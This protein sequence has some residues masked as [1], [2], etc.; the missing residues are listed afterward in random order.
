MVTEEEVKAGMCGFQVLIDPMKVKEISAE[1]DK[2]RKRAKLNIS[3]TADNIMQEG[4]TMI[5]P[6]SGQKI[7]K[8][9][10]TLG[11]DKNQNK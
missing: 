10:A 6:L 7:E 2:Q 9:D 11:S 3:N 5:D 1:I 4:E 8:L